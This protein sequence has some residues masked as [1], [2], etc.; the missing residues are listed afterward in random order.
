[1]SP[2]NN[3]RFSQGQAIT[4]VWTDVTGAASYTIQIDDSDRFTSPLLM[5]QPA[6]TSTFKTS[7]LPRAKL[8]W[9]AR[10]NDGTGNPGSWSSVR[11][12]RTD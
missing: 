10:A 8:W 2:P 12:V 11:G 4:F 9:R 5:D 3:A 6:D 1:M 7:A